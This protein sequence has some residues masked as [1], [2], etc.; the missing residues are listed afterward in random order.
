MVEGSSA[1]TSI[2][3]LSGRLICFAA[4]AAAGG[5]MDGSEGAGKGAAIGGAIAVLTKVKERVPS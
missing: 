2:C 5:I 3:C 1:S 4:G